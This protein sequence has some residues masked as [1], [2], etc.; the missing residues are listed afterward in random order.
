[1]YNYVVLLGRLTK[2][3][4]VRYTKSEKV[5]AGFTLAVDRPFKNQNGDRDADFIPI[6]MWGKLAE[7]IGNNVHKGQRLLVS[8]RL[9]VR[10]YDDKDGKKVWVTEVIA[11]NVA[12]IEKR[13]HQ[14]PP[15]GQQAQASGSV[16][17]FAALGEEIDF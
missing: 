17:A 11:N 13:E 1:M 12:F 6:V 3:P 14:N 2:D 16:D 4:D 5:T 8:G 7:T 9:Q 15:A 10:T